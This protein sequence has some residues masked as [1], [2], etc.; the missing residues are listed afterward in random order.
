MVTPAPRCSLACY[1][2][3]DADKDTHDPCMVTLHLGLCLRS[4]HAPFSLDNKSYGFPNDKSP[5]PPPQTE[6]SQKLL[7]AGLARPRMPGPVLS[8]RLGHYIPMIPI[9]QTKKLRSR[10]AVATL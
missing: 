7:S 6:G 8:T 10:E 2:V 5:P 9:W 4:Q 1:H 3:Q